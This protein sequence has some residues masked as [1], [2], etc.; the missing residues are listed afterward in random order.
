MRPNLR[1]EGAKLPLCDVRQV[2][3]TLPSDGPLGTQGDMI[4][5][6]LDEMMLPGVLANKF[7]QI[8]TSQFLAEQ[9]NRC[10]PCVFLDIGANAGLISRQVLVASSQIRH[11]VCAEPDPVNYSCLV[12]NL[13]QFEDVTLVNAGLAD[14]DGVNQ[15]YR[16]KT[17]AGNYSFN[18]AAVEGHEH[19]VT[20]TR[21]L[22]VERFFEQVADELGEFPILWKSDTQGFD[23]LIVSRTPDRVWDKVRCAVIEVWRID[24][25]DFDKKEFCRRI[26]SFANKQLGDEKISSSE[27][28]MAYLASRD[29]AHTDLLLWR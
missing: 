19:T 3:V 2:S 21:T 22:A 5:M 14:A 27:D 6:S 15:F 16:Q 17:N 25:P 9:G 7:W 10:G 12:Q 24:K 26:D 29:R 11:V 1:R 13:A 23:E 20:Q 4:A 28:V 8:E 18:Q